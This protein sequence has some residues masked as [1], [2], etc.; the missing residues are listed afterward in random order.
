MEIGMLWFDESDRSLKDRVQEAAGFYAE[1]Y[2]QSP[3]LC[4]VHPSMVNGE[5]NEI[6]EIQLRKARSVMPNHFWVGIDEKANGKGR[7]ASKPKAA[8]TKKTDAGSKKNGVKQPKQ[9]K[10]KKATVKSATTKA[11]PKSKAKTKPAVPK[12][13]ATNARA[14]KAA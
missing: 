11:Q 3:T 14:K 4:M 2:G 8:K 7:S 9:T 1:K 6:G 13:K 12:A 5:G 10:P